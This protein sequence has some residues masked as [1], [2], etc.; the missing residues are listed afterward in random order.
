[1]IDISKIATPDLYFAA[2]LKAKS[3]QIVDVQREGQKTIFTFDVSDSKM[4]T[5]ELKQGYF[6]NDN[7]KSAVCALAFADAIRSLKTLCHVEDNEK[8][9]TADLYFAA[10][11]KTKKCSI[12]SIESKNGKTIFVFNVTNSGLSVLELKLGYFNNINDTKCVVNASD[13]TDAVKSLKTMCHI[14]ND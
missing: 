9:I 3:C 14:T 8:I 5:A 2:Y 11:L 10:Y 13:Y 12:E 7:A 4:T 1:M 6:N